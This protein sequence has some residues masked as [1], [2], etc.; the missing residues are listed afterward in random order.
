MSHLNYLAAELAQ[1]QQLGIPATLIKVSELQSLLDQMRNLLLLPKDPVRVCG[2]AKP[3]ELKALYTGTLRTI[4][5][6]RSRTA[7]HTQAVYNEFKEA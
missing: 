6:H 4:K 5:L 1:A 2:F 3:G 7:W